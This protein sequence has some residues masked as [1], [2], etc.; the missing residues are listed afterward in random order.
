MRGL[1]LPYMNERKWSLYG[2]KQMMNSEKLGQVCL[3][4]QG[5]CNHHKTALPVMKINF[6]KGVKESEVQLG[7]MVMVMNLFIDQFNLDMDYGAF[8]VVTMTERGRDCCCCWY[9]NNQWI[10]TN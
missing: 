9:Q 7:S 2:P 4:Q 6:N 3:Y 10:P 1:Q 5:N 8:P